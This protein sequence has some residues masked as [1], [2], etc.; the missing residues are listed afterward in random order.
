MIKL[1]DRD[2]RLP[3]SWVLTHW[4]HISLCITK[5]LTDEL[6]CW[7]IT[8]DCIDILFAH[9]QHNHWVSDTIIDSIVFFFSSSIV[10]K[11]VAD[12]EFLL[13]QLVFIAEYDQAIVY[14]FY[15]RT[16]FIFSTFQP[17]LYTSLT[18]PPSGII[19][20]TTFTNWPNPGTNDLL[21]WCAVKRHTNKQV[22]ADENKVYWD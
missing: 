17:T 16:N 22:K 20:S 13:K 12:E 10:W 3:M 18:Q 7:L 19:S 21:C 1:V 11:V 4:C 14:H 9:V 5:S 15:V 8:N 6:R 2:S